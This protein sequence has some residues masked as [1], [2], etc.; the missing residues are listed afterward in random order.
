VFKANKLRADVVAPSAYVLSGQT[1]KAN[2]ILGASSTDLTPERMEVL[3]GGVYD[4]TA[5]KLIVPGSS[6]TIKDGMGTFETMTNA[7]G[8][9][10][11]KG[12]IK[13]KN[14]RGEDEYY[15]FSFPYTV[16]PPF[17][18]VAADN[19]NIFYVGVDNPVSVSSAGFSP[20]DLKVSVSG[21]GAEMKTNGAGK[22]TLTAKS[23]GTCV[24]TVSVKTSEGYKQ[25]G[26]PK[27]FRIK[28]I[29]PPVLKIGGKLATSNL[30]FNRTDIAK[31]GG[32]GA[33]SPGFMFPVSMVV[34]SFDLEIASNGNL[35]PYKCIGNNFTPQA[36]QALSNMR[37][38]QRAFFDNVKVQ[39]PTGIVSLPMAQIKVK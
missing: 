36:K 21:C 11:L 32:L 28:S 16:A 17:T 2:I 20:S 12:V 5:K 37:P 24:V 18:A 19:M 39:T 3:V 25:Q 34:K 23:S 4:T 22:Y 6:I 10:D 8:L 33:E 1:F 14:P 15:P 29:P 35:V 9:K 27:V 13:Y 38:G 30:E 26:A 31:I 7:T